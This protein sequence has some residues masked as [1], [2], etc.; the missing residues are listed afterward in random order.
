MKNIA[1]AIIVT[2]ASTAALVGSR[3]FLHSILWIEK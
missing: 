2:V 3:Q 1:L